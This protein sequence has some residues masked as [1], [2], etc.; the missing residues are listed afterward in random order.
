M[1]RAPYVVVGAGGHA[2]VVIATIE[3][4]GGEVVCVLDDDPGRHGSRVLGHLVRGAVTDDLIPTDALV[5]LGIGDNGARIRIAASL[6]SAAGSVV[7]PSAVVHPSVTIGEGS[8]VFA[9]AI[10]QPGTVLGRHVIVNTGATVDH[11]CVLGDGVHVAPGV[12]LAGG[13]RLDDGVFMGIGSCA[14]P[15]TRVG[16]WSTVGAGGVVVADIPG[17]VIATGVPARTSRKS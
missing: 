17:A 7:H 4:A 13:V 12:H 2:K 8:V 11:D 16:A 5:V 14:T 9:G 15:Y 6:R 1:G 3:A 10:I